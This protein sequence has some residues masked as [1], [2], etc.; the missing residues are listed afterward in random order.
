MVHSAL[1]ISS[2]KTTEKSFRFQ[3]EEQ[4]EKDKLK[5]IEQQNHKELLLNK[6]SI[7]TELVDDL[8]KKVEE[9]NNNVAKHTPSTDLDS[10]AVSSL[11]CRPIICQNWLSNNN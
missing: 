4:N 11:G 5:E 3:L 7:L 6:I 8:Q 1:Y 2:L 9:S 10:N